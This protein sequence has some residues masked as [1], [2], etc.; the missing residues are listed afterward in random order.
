MRPS[1]GV[2]Q[3]VASNTDSR[4]VYA[5]P[6]FKRW[7]EAEGLIASEQFLVE[8]YLR[9]D[10]S[11]LEAGVGGGRILRALTRLGFEDIYGFDNVPG[12]IEQARRQDPS[13]ETAYSVQDAR[14][15]IYPDGVF[16][17]L[18]YLQQVIS[19][20]GDVEGGRKAVAEAYRVLKPGGI[21]LF[22]F[23]CYE[24]RMRSVW[25]R[26]MIAYL[27]CLRTLAR[28]HRPRQSMPW[29]RLGGRFNV[30]AL[31]DRPPLVY[32]F[33]C[34]EAAHLLADQHFTIVGIGTRTQTDQ[35][36]L[37][38]SAGELRRK[39]MNGMLYVVCRK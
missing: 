29:L 19:L 20:I 10:G 5:G 34:E 26:A 18:I 32:W 15:L 33:R 39:P 30:S 24:S 12:L 21:A 1:R 31:L 22:S 6:E 13:R 4:Q 27:A 35:R 16:D 36:T 38:R 17:Q 25:Y 11:T 28:Q 3:S 23:L 7:A 2:L 8:C 37:C 9:R 14:K